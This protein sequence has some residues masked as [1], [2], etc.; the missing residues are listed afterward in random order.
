MDIQTNG[1]SHPDGGTEGH[2][3]AQVI[4][5]MLGDDSGSAD[6]APF[7]QAVEATASQVEERMQDLRSKAAALDQ[8]V[9]QQQSA[10]VQY[11][12][13]LNGFEQKIHGVEQQVQGVNQQ[14]Q[15]IERQVQ[16]S[17]QRVQGVEQ[18]LTELGEQLT[19]LVRSI[20]ELRGK[21]SDVTT[22]MSDVTTSIGEMNREIASVKE[23]A[24]PPIK[25]DVEILKAQPRAVGSSMRLKI[26][27]FLIIVVGGYSIIG[28][29]GWNSVVAMLP[30]SVSGMF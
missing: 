12:T 3:G 7:T 11:E 19:A 22:T 20:D 18:V 27:V 24:I 25:E 16:V 2:G 4:P 28:K 17:D 21:V 13:S 23:T 10:M 30:P 8:N 15:G 9:Q 29:P 1:S 14:I 5:M 6:G 26:V